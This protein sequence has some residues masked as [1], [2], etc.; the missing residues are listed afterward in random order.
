MNAIREPSGDHVSGPV[1]LGRSISSSMLPP[2]GSVSARREVGSNRGSSWNRA[3]NAMRS[4]AP[5]QWG[6]N[7]LW[8]GWRSSGRAP[9]PSR[10]AIHTWP[11]PHSSSDLTKRRDLESGDHAGAESQYPSGVPRSSSL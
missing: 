10:F 1:P 2:P 8:S 6:S 7:S 3:Q 5:D 4:L 9:L 11:L